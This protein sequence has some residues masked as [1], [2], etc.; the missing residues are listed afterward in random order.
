MPAFTTV[1]VPYGR[2]DVDGFLR[3]VA[4]GWGAGTLAA[5]AIEVEG[6]SLAASTT[7]DAGIGVPM[8]VG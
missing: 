3:H 8:R 5:F 7:L 4:E 6:A 1:P 2:A